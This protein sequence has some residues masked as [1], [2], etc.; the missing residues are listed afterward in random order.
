MVLFLTY[1]EVLCFHLKSTSF[2]KYDDK[3]RT[4]L[5]FILYP[6]KPHYSTREKKVRGV[7]YMDTLK[8]KHNSIA[9]HSFNTFSLT[10]VDNENKL[11][12]KTTVS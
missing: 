10:S 9:N 12:G 11:R 7:A 4:L 6:K 2:I 1:S 5:R 8:Q 3:K